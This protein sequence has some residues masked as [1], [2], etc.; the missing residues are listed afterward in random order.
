MAVGF[1]RCQIV[2]CNT[3]SLLKM[4][5]SCDG[6]AMHTCKHQPARNQYIMSF[7]NEYLLL[8]PENQTRKRIVLNSIPIA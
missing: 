3:I 4:Q 1:M 8:N 6:K 7:I 5:Y 2:L